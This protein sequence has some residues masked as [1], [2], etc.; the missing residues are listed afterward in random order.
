MVERFG[1]EDAQVKPGAA[2][3]V[4]VKVLQNVHLTVVKETVQ[5]VI[6]DEGARS[7]HSLLPLPVWS[8][9]PR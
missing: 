6:A 9:E 8:A 3:V 1:I 2:G 7:G 5:F 4:R